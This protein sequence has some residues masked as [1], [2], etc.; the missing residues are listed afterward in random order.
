[1]DAVWLNRRRPEFRNRAT[2]RVVVDIRHDQF[3]PGIVQMSRQGM[4]RR[5]QPLRWEPSEEMAKDF[6]FKVYGLAPKSAAD[7]AFLLHGFHFLAK[8]GTMAIIL[9]H[10][11]LFRGGAEKKIRTKLLKDGN[12]DTV[13]GLPAKLFYS[14]GIPVCILV[15]KKCKRTDDVLFINAAE[16]YQPGKRQNTLLQEHINKIVETY[17]HRKEEDRYSRVVSLD[18]IEKEHDFNLN[19]SRYVST[20]EPEEEVDLVSVHK[21]LSDLQT[22]ISSA[23]ATHNR[24]L[25]ELGITPLPLG[26]E[27]AT[28]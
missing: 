12:I 28:D 19:I 22:Q 5:T 13:I 3:R 26:F 7:F 17:Q 10:G 8:D 6:R 16:H 18:E 14:T 27:K 23:A 24:Y 1:M 15:L 11:V 20:A 2:H 21:H 4:A 25:K 9:P